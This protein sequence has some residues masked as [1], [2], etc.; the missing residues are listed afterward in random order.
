MA[1]DLFSLGD[2]EGQACISPNQ[3][4]MASRY[5]VVFP[6][7]VKNPMM[8]FYGFLIGWCMTLGI[9]THLR[10]DMGSEFEAGFAEMTEQVGCKLL[11]TAAVSPT[12]NRPC[13]RARRAWKFHAQTLIDQFSIK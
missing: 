9:P 2:C 1:V 5:N 13:E 12:S 8:V 6:I 7:D 10:F 11:P 3:L 4:D